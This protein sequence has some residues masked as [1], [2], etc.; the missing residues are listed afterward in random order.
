VA[1]VAST[2]GGAGNAGA[3]K[4]PEIA[5]AGAAPAADSGAV[6]DKAGSAGPAIAPVAALP[7]PSAPVETPVEGATLS[8]DL[9]RNIQTELVRVG[10]AAGSADGVWGKKGRSAV[11]AF[12]RY[13]KI[14]LASLDPSEDLLSTLKG[15]G[16]RACPLACGTRYEAKGDSCVLKTCPKGMSLNGGG[17]CA[18]PPPQPKQAAP[19]TS[20]GTKATASA[21]GGGC[22]KETEAQCIG[23]LS[24]RPWRRERVRQGWDERLRDR[25]TVQ[26]A[27]EPHLPVRRA[28]VPARAGLSRREA[29]EVQRDPIPSGRREP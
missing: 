15:Y 16:G 23:R 25:D 29:P 12:A 9:V 24:F 13:S 18:A 7:P 21:S 2:D 22:V 17:N 20:G 26:L 6:T 28:A 5:P 10:C 4:L 8:P 11:E 27:G 14:S 1:E 19:A 3:A